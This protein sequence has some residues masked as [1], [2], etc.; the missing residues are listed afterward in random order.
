MLDSQTLYVLH[1]CITSALGLSAYHYVPTHY[2][3]PGRSVKLVRSDG[4][5]ICRRRD[6]HGLG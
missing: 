4:D 5:G 6:G 3:T 2:L 1:K